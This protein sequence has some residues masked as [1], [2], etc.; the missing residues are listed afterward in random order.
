ME[1]FARGAGVRLARQQLPALR[2][3]AAFDF[4]GGKVLAVEEAAVVA[5]LHQFDEAQGYGALAHEIERVG[6]RA[7][8]VAAQ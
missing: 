8:G 2:L 7:L 5:G 6:Q 1:I 4:G 3:Q